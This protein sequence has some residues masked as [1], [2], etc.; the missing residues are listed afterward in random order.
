MRRIERLALGSL[1]VACGITVGAACSSTPAVPA[2][3]QFVDQLQQPGVHRFDAVVIGKDG[4]PGLSA[5]TATCIANA[6]EHDKWPLE[7]AVQGKV[8]TGVDV[9]LLN[10]DISACEKDPGTTTIGPFG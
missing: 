8:P 7:A 5:D 3:T 1:L 6:F 10:L 2:R 9:K 4:A